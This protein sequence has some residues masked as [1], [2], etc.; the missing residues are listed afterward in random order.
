HSGGVGN[1]TRVTRLIHAVGGTD[2]GKIA[3]FTK[4]LLDKQNADGGWSWADDQPSD[5]FATGQALFGLAKA[6]RKADDPAVARGCAYLLK[7]QRPDGS[8]YAPTKKPTGKNH[9]IA[10]YWASAWATIGLVQFHAGGTG[11]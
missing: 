10:T 6:G 3:G 8:W 2:N 7:T 5:P 1:E 9:V 4:D 11:K